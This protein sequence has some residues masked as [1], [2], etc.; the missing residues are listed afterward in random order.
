MTYFL[1]DQDN[2]GNVSGELDNDGIYQHPGSVMVSSVNITRG[3]WQTY[4]LKRY[5]DMRVIEFL[6]HFHGKFTKGNCNNEL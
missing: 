5:I 1:K 2:D 6:I 3:K 4:L